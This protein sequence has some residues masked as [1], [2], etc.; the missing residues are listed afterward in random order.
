MRR[1]ATAACG[2]ALGVLLLGACRDTPAP[3]S[4]RGYPSDALDTLRALEAAL[5]STP[6]TALLREYAR[7][8]SEEPHHAGSPGSR[9]V[10]EW[11]LGKFREWGLQAEIELFEA[12]MP[13]PISRSVELV[14]PTRFAAKMRESV[15]AQDKDSG[16]DN[17][18]PTYNA[19]GADGDVEGELVFANYGLAEDY[20]HLDSVGI[21]LRGKI[22]IVKYGRGVRSSKIKQAVERGAIGCIIYSDPEED[23]FTRGEVYPK[24]PWRPADAVQRGTALDY[25]AMY[26][27]DPL[28]PGWSSKPGGRRLSRAE[29][30]SLPQIPVVPLSYGDAQP[31]LEAL[32]GPAAPNDNW[33]GGLQIS[34]H[35][36]PGPARVRLRSKSEWKSRPLYNVVGRIPGA[37]EPNEWVIFANHHD[38]WVNGAWDPVSAAAALME[39]ARSLSVLMKNGWQPRRTII[40]ALWD[41]EEWGLLGST[42]WAEEHADE[43]RDK[44]VIYFN[45]DS[46]ARGTFDAQGSHTLETF[47]RE[48]ARDLIDPET[49]GNVID[50]AQT[51]DLNNAKSSADSAQLRQRGFELGAPGSGT[52]YEAFLEHL[53]IATVNHG[54]SGGPG[55]GVYHSIYDSY[56]HYTKFMDP[57]F[58]YGTAQSSAVATFA[59]RMAD[60][61]LLP[62]SFTDAATAYK[63]FAQDV[64]ALADA[65]LGSERLDVSPVLQAIDR[66]GTAGS[67]VDRAYDRLMQRGSAFIAGA[68]VPLQAINRDLYQSERDL[69]DPAGLPGREWFKSTMYATGIYTGFAPD[70]M[71]GVRQMLEAKRLD[72]AQEQVR[73][74]AA[75]VDR[76]ARRAARVATALEEVAR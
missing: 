66:L 67:D 36:G 53:G 68:R 18:L 11:A 16:D 56:D 4:V 34:Y 50:A 76:M 37:A 47:V 23:G 27:G 61:P 43:L 62:F 55:A 49:G 41:G 57:G 51:R 19:Y 39:A 63:R 13:T 54:F 20:A 6:D 44:A 52:D 29:A 14:H 58:V 30:K 26:A 60:A 12:L 72:A 35:L 64:L 40:F 45:T 1:I 46:Y 73:R 8:M 10:A 59:L 70:P 25:A 33:E 75:A 17:Q 65:R 48:M 21:D 9:A 31:L 22:V 32:G 5:R 28:S 24:G 42:E 2:C 15:L 3:P 7:V 38:G 69:L 71:P 74:V